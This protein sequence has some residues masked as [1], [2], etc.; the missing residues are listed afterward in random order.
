MLFYQK[1]KVLICFPGIQGIVDRKRQ[2]GIRNRGG[3]CHCTKKKK[4]LFVFQESKVSSTEREKEELETEKVN[5][6]VPK[7]EKA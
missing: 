3:E 2:G 5:V 1:E 4:S 6:I 7:R